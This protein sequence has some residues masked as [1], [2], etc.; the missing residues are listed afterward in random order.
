MDKLQKLHIYFIV[1]MLILNNE[2]YSVCNKLTTIIYGRLVT[3]F[4]NFRALLCVNK[5]L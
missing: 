4:T 5:S 3:V 1:D 2:M